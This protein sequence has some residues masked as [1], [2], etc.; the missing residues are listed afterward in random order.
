M[1]RLKPVNIGSILK[2]NQAVLNRLDNKLGRIEEKW[3]PDHYIHTDDLNE[4]ETL[5]LKELETQA[6]I[7]DLE[8]ALNSL[9]DLGVYDLQKSLYA[10]EEDKVVIQA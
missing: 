7:A 9:E 2:E 3:K 5:Q 4:S 1:I 10:W 8:S 6:G